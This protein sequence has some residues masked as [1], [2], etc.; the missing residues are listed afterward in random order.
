ME[1]PA[2][3][4]TKVSRKP[5]T[6]D[7]HRL[8]LRLRRRRRALLNVK[9]LAAAGNLTAANCLSFSSTIRRSSETPIT[10]A[11]TWLT[12]CLT[13]IV[14][15]LLLGL[16]TSVRPVPAFA[17]TA[18]TINFQ[19]RLETVGGAIAPDGDYNVEFKL[20]NASSS[21][22]SSQGSCTGDANCLWTETRTG[23]DK[24]HVANGYLT[25]NLGS[26]TA[27]PA[28][29]WNQQLWLSMRIGGTGTPSWDTEMSPRLSLTAVPAAYAL[30]N[31]SGSVSSSL[32]LQAGTGSAGLQNFVVPDQG[33]PGTYTLGVYN[34]SSANGFLLLQNATA[35]TQQSGHFNISGT[36]IAGTLQ[37]ATFDTPSG[38]TTLNIGTTNATA[39]I[40]LN[41]NVTIV[42]GKTLS[43]NGTS[44]LAG[45]TVNGTSATTIDTVQSSLAVQIPT[46]NNDLNGITVKAPSAT[47]GTSG[48]YGKGQV[49]EYLK[50]NASPTTLPDDNVLFRID[51]TGGIGTGGGVH[52]ATGLRQDAGYAATQAV[53]INPQMDLVGEVI[54]AYST[55]TQPLLLLQANGGG[56]LVQVTGSG[57]L[58]GIQ[59]TNT[60]P[61][62]SFVG[63]TNTGIYNSAADT[64]DFVTGG[65]SRLQINSSGQ[66]GIGT[67]GTTGYQLDLRNTTSSQLHITGNGTND[68][69]TYLTS[70][71]GGLTS[72]GTNAAYNGTN[73]VAKAANVSDIAQFNGNLYFRSN[74]GLTIGSTF[75]PTVRLQV[76]PSGN[77][78]LSGT[79]AVQG[80]SL[81]IGVGGTTAGSLNLA[82]ATSTRMVV[83]QGANP[84]GTGNATVTIPSIAGGSSDTVCLQTLANCGGG[85]GVTTI[86]AL[87]GGTYSAN[88]ASISGTTLYLQAATGTHVGLVTTG[89][90]TFAGDKTF[91]GNL[92]VS[93]STTISGQLTVDSTTLIADDSTHTVS[94][95][96]SGGLKVTST[97]TANATKSLIQVGNAISGGNASANGGTYIGLNAPSSGA[98]SVADLINLQNGGVGMFAVNHQGDAY[99]NGG[100]TVSDFNSAGILL[101]GLTHVLAANSSSSSLLVNNN[102]GTSLTVQGGG[103]QGSK[104]TV[105]IQ[106][107]NSGQTGDLLQLQDGAG[108][109]AGKFNATGNQLTLGRIT[110]SGT[111][112]QGKLVLADG[113]ADNF[114]LTLQSS[115]ITASRIYSFPNSTAA[116]DTVCLQT[117]A[118]CSGGTAISLGTYSTTNTDAHGA[119]LSGGV[120]TFQS[121]SGSAP[122]MVDTGAQTFWGNKTFVNDTTFGSGNG[123]VSVQGY[124]DISGSST[125]PSLSITTAPASGA[126]K[127]LIKIG[128]AI[129]GG[130]A[131]ANGGTYI[132]LNAPS[133]GAG[134]AADFINLQA[135]GSSVFKISSQGVINI[136]ATSGHTSGNVL[137]IVD[138]QLGQTLLAVNENF[139]TT[140]GGLH[141][142][143]IGGYAVF[144]GGINVANNA[145]SI[146]RVSS[147]VSVDATLAQ[148]LLGNTL[149]GGNAV[150]NGGTYVG[151]NAPNTGAGS[152]ADFL[153][154]QKNGSTKFQ[155]FNSGSAI[156]YGSF[157]AVDGVSSALQGN[158]L[159]STSASTLTIG[160]VNATALSVD[161]N[162]TFTSGKTLTV[163]GATTI[164][165]ASSSAL[166]VQNTSNQTVL[167]A[168]TSA[169][170]ALVGS[171]SGVNGSL[172]IS[173]S[174]AS[175][176][177]ELTVSSSS[178]T[179]Y[180]LT[181]PNAAPGGTGQ[182]LKSGAVTANNLE[183]GSCGSGGGGGVTHKVYLIPEYAGGIITADGSSNT[184][185]ITSDYDSTNRHSYYSW[186]SSQGALNDYDVIARSQIPSEY[187]GSLGSFKIWVQNVAAVSATTSADVQ[188]TVRDGS[189]TAC[190]TS[191]SVLPLSTSTWTEQSVTLSGC[192]FAANDILTID[193]KAFSKSNNE[194]RI[195]EL[196]YT[197]TN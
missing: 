15:S 57:Q 131:S 185:T 97:P 58:Q 152:A 29:I 169:G 148:V 96:G 55:Q 189:G 138:S 183:F 140:V 28:N 126:T 7:Y 11:R 102:S 40:N 81:T 184:G 127:S 23:T 172:K 63:D 93:L 72:L 130:N 61:S 13:L 176:Y 71:L 6:R 154:F 51:R 59:G 161:L 104:A 16:L 24:V 112:Y 1:I 125:N 98:G 88:G 123:T 143:A 147:P 37:A 179:G 10:N 66:L 39:G 145:G 78:T 187:T 79:L 121:A 75:T 167:G 114:G 157:L 133:A 94:V 70:T 137:N 20:Y 163:N 111:A 117:L 105:V 22:G 69:G 175:G 8:M 99:L 196:S 80:S 139:V 64:L 87:D 45:L 155:I 193:A 194:V 42:S 34:S 191:T 33:T 116:T 181:L 52:I 2:S 135:N 160:Q 186:T 91:S 106:N 47:W 85:S 174:A 73:F 89:T 151:L 109:V 68:N 170:K 108:L 67:S 118:N 134:S 83:L 103:G 35:G 178:F 182:C 56:T 9:R 84:S 156:S 141:V 44:T 144:D 165:T 14:F 18:N 136:Q 25:V 164:K 195:G 31:T 36:G 92:Q 166:I 149:V 158:F 180:S 190:A 101:N 197:Y 30:T 110:A 124:L 188:V 65:T 192:T 95:G 113:T 77:G 41:Q 159:D 76:D 3:L 74:S 128:S 168:D 53:W 54:T 82:N 49:F 5:F 26:V 17:A 48:N 132:G 122:G 4:K 38:T 86:G 115:T 50:Y 19:A 107:D 32:T 62:L 100:L 21:S 171:N 12:L 60:A 43:V 129:A 146:L 90:Q 162:T 177:V 46:G 27:L 173:S 142:N 119:T 153:N 150:A 120:L